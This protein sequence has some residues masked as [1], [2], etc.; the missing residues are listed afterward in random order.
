MVINLSKRP[1]LDLG[2]TGMFDEFG[3]YPTS[4]IRSG[5]EVLAY[6]GGWTRC[7]SVPFDV[8]IGL[9][10]SHDNGETFTRLG[11]GPVLSSSLAEP[12]IISGPKI[13]RFEDT[14]HLWYIAGRKWIESAGRKEPI[15]KIRKAHSMDG[16]Y[17]IK[18]DRDLILDSL[19]VN[20]SQASPD[21]FFYRNQYHMFFCYR[22]GTN[23]RG[24]RGYRIG[25]ASSDDLVHWYR[26]DAQVG[27]DISDTG[28][29]SETISYPHVFELDGTVYMFYLGDQLG[30][31]IWT[32]HS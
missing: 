30:V 23:Y 4:V 3:I 19:G 18:D 22:H 1:I 6:Y 17:W 28:W 31:C 26:D 15:Y 32:A 21:V 2:D 10:V 11:N 8:S 29:D 13:R 5:S 9:A 14:W 16:I 12:F 25:Y 7:E 24:P 27:I 20:E